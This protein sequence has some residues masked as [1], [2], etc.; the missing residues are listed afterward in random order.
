MNPIGPYQTAIKH[1]MFKKWYVNKHLTLPSHF[2]YLFFPHCCMFEMCSN[3]VLI[4]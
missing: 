3:D 4:M 1:S 2:I